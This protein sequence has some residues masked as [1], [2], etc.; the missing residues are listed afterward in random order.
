MRTTILN[1]VN[2]LVCKFLYYDRKEDEALPVGA[3]EDAIESET[4]TVDD[5]VTQFRVVLE[6]GIQR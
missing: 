3:I 4:I 1:N 6:R 5:I 2:D